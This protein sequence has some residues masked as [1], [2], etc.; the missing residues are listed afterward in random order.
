M[1]PSRSARSHTTIISPAAITRPG[2]TPDGNSFEIDC[3]AMTP[4]ITKAMD[5]GI[6]GA[7]TPALTTSWNRLTARQDT[8]AGQSNACYSLDQNDRNRGN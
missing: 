1:V 3:S 8:W 5:G 2:T 7:R 6:S 4:Q